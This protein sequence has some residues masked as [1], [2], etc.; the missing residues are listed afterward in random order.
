VICPQNLL[1]EP[2]VEQCQFAN[3]GDESLSKSPS[4]LSNLVYVMPLPGVTDPQAESAMAAMK[5]LGYPV[6]AVR[7][8]SK[9]W[10]S[11]LSDADTTLLQSKILCNDSIE[12]IVLGKLELDQLQLGQKY[13]FEKRDIPLED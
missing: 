7:T 10:V 4:D 11:D 8:F 6:E 1:V 5:Q 9:Y 13:E 2:V 3:V 12:T